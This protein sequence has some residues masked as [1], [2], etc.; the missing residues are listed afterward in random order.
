MSQRLTRDRV[1]RVESETLL[2]GQH[3]EDTPQSAR[4]NPLSTTLPLPSDASTDAFAQASGTARYHAF[5]TAS[6][7][8]QQEF[9]YAPTVR[10]NSTPPGRNF[11]GMYDGDDYGNMGPEMLMRQ[12][13]ALDLKDRVRKLAKI[14][15]KHS[16]DSHIYFSYFLS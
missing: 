1:G 3:P 6:P 16:A 10:S 13:A 9:S 11:G 2:R 4:N 12:F 15:T 5:R 14:C 7:S 8:L